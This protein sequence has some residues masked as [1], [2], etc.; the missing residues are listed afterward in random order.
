M[1][2]QQQRMGTD[3]L[4]GA[5]RLARTKAGGVALELGP[6]RAVGSTSWQLAGEVGYGSEWALGAGQGHCIGSVLGNDGPYSLC[7]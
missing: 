4:P 1:Q 7:L 6:A 5:G 3:S 2:S